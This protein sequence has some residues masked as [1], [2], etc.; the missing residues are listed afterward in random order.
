MRAFR[1]R[2]DRIL[3]IRRKQEEAIRLEIAR[4]SAEIDRIR[5]EIRRECERLAAAR[6]CL[7]GG[8]D[9]WRNRELFLRAGQIV[10]RRLETLEAER[11]ALNQERGRA[12]EAFEAAMRA[13]KTLER[14]REE[15]LARHRTAED[16]TEQ[17]MLDE[18]VHHRITRELATS[19]RG[20]E[21]TTR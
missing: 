7:G 15:A 12:L 13:R 1:W 18:G 21:V 10:E 3:E 5:R 16:K 19:R 6:G 14:L 4:L 17:G 8:P 11:V 2:L 20:E 9:R